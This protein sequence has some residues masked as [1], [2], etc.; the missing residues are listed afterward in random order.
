M[1]C[2]AKKKQGP[3]GP[4]GAKRDQHRSKN[5]VRIPDDVFEAVRRLAEQNDRP[6]TREIRQALIAWLEAKGCWPPQE[7]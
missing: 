5:M 7:R 4:H 2:M 1:L 6:I 3:A